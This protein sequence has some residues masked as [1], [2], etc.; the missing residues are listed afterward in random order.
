[1]FTSMKIYSSR[2]NGMRKN[3]CCQALS[4]QTCQRYIQVVYYRLTRLSDDLNID[5][6]D[7]SYQKQ[8]LQ[9]SKRASDP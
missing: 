2:V 5:H 8:Q 6:T 7:G 9:L 4:E 3:V 1:M